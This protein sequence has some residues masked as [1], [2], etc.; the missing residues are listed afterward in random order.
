MKINPNIMQKVAQVQMWRLSYSLVFQIQEQDASLMRSSRRLFHPWLCK[1]KIR[2]SLIVSSMY[3]Y[4]RCSWKDNTNNSKSSYN[5]F[6]IILLIINHVKK[7]LNIFCVS[8]VLNVFAFLFNTFFMKYKGN[9]WEDVVGWYVILSDGGNCI[10]GVICLTS[11]YSQ[12][13]GLNDPLYW[14]LY[15]GHTSCKVVK[16]MLS[17]IH[18]FSYSYATSSGML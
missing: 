5:I 15:F 10:E 12:T 7:V 6:L 16:C 14:Y 13:Y 9:Y 11:Q 18:E 8:K 17:F 1:I 3:M 4:P 2:V